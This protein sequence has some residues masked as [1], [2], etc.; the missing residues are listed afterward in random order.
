M[1]AKTDNDLILEF[2]KI[3]L[4]A[5]KQLQSISLLMEKNLGKKKKTEWQQI[6]EET[7]SE[8]RILYGYFLEF[9]PNQE[10]V[11]YF[12]ETKSKQLVNTNTAFSPPYIPYF[13]NKQRTNKQL[14]ELLENSK[15]R[16]ESIIDSPKVYQH[17]PIQKKGSVP[18]EYISDEYLNCYIPKAIIDKTDYYVVLFDEIVFVQYSYLLKSNEN[19]EDYFKG[20]DKF[21]FTYL[22]KF[23]LSVEKKISKKPTLHQHLGLKQSTSFWNTEN[24]NIIRNEVTELIKAKKTLSTK[25]KNEC[26]TIVNNIIDQ[27]I[28]KYK[29]KKHYSKI[30]DV[31]LIKHVSRFDVKA[32]FKILD[33]NN[34]LVPHDVFVFPLYTEKKVIHTTPYIHHKRSIDLHSP[35]LLVLYIKTLHEIKQVYDE[36][37]T[38]IDGFQITKE[39]AKLFA[40][41]IIQDDYLENVVIKETKHQATRAAISQVMARNMSHNIGSHVLNNLTDGTALSRI[42]NFVCH[43]YIPAKEQEDLHKEARIIYQLAIYNNYVKCRMDYLSDITFGTPVMHTNKK[44]RE[45]LYKDFDKVRLLLD[46]ISGL[47]KNFPFKVEFSFE[48]KEITSEN[49]FSVALPNDLLGCQAFYN[50]IENVIRNT[51]KYNQN[52]SGATTFTIN[53]KEI[54]DK[55]KDVVGKELWY[56][57][58]I[59]DDIEVVENKSGTFVSKIRS[60]VKQQN[61]KINMS[62]LEGNNQLRTSSLGLLEME[63]SAAY[64]RKLDITDIEDDHYNIEDNNKISNTQ[65]RLNV[66]KAF[67][68]NGALGYRFFVSKPTEFLFVGEFGISK[69]QQRKLAMKGIWV[70]TEKEFVEQLKFN[71]VFN[72]QILAYQETQNINSHIELYPT[73][74]PVRKIKLQNDVEITSLLKTNFSFESVEDWIWKQWFEQIKLG[75]ESIN[76]FKTYSA[77]NKKHNQQNRYNIAL[78]HHI[79]DEMVL[80]NCL[81]NF[82][83][84]NINSFDVLSSNAKNKLPGMKGAFVD[85][86]D[87]LKSNDTLKIK[88]FEASKSKVVVID[89]RIQKYADSDEKYFGLTHREIFEYTNVIIPNKIELASE[90]YSKNVSQDIEQFVAE[91]IS[92]NT[93]A[94]L[95]VHYSILERMYGS[96]SN[97]IDVTL[98]EWAKQTRVVVTSGRGKPPDLP[99]QFVCYV[100]LSPILNAFTQVR[101][102]YAINYL[103]NTARK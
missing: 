88:L 22:V 89:E 27:L 20:R 52:K 87:E 59:Y 33:E 57:V 24:E 63:A 7:L 53:F 82:K 67:D 96:K 6:F 65:K 78:S 48:G 49:D 101:S 98:K 100:N 34:R 85:Y 92:N 56:E 71:V 1:A 31:N 70:R 29:S 72:H 61:D 38:S 60:L 12:I 37:E 86:L 103:L 15:K 66:L 58:E 32:S 95:V 68:K 39:I 77:A 2:S 3:F 62:V 13:P 5:S 35:V 19:I 11:Q 26:L 28:D 8:L 74:L 83:L 99:S 18:F 80:N 50:I 64:L 76:I 9:E 102:K 55:G 44:V 45:E 91:Q 73:N 84:G 16:F 10:E 25:W 47:S 40:E 42:E 30:T 43:S 93:S 51:A 79:E 4:N 46:H 94:F 21:L 90:N 81:Q 54:S 17:L 36:T 69:N 14:Y 97:Q 41:R 75:Y 23:A